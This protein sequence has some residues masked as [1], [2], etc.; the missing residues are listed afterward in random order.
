LFGS[1]AGRSGF[2]YGQN[3]H[4]SRLS[5]TFG[6]TKRPKQKYT[7]YDFTVGRSAIRLVYTLHRN[8]FIVCIR[9]VCFTDCETLDHHGSGCHRVVLVP[10]NLRVTRKLLYELCTTTRDC[11]ICAMCYTHTHDV[12]GRGGGMSPTPTD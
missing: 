4:R 9:F 12:F 11:K 8:K 3:K 1:L 7:F 6:R 5:Y 2:A 10:G